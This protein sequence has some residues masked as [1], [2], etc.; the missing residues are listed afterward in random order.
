MSIQISHQANI[1]IPHYYIILYSGLA[2]Y[3]YGHLEPNRSIELNRCYYNT[4]VDES[5]VVEEKDNTTYCYSRKP[6]SECEDCQKTPIENIYTVHFTASCGKPEWCRKNH[7]VDLCME[8][9]FRWHDIR[10]S[11]E[12]EWLDKFPG[13]NPNLFNSSTVADMDVL[14]Q[15]HGHCDPGRNQGY[16]PLTFPN[17]TYSKDQLLIDHHFRA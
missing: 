3:Y 6:I 4:M 7:K 12:E 2:S 15:Y 10:L 14:N 8:L 1:M 9:F 5:Y 17:T 11:L 13:Y 16:I